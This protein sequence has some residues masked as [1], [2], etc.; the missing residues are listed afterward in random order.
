[1]KLKYLITPLCAV[2]LISAGPAT[3]Q[4]QSKP[5]GQIT[6]GWVKSTANL[7]AFVSPTISEQYGLKIESANFNTA[8]DIA[9]AMISGQVDVGLLT[10]IHLIR[11]I[12]TKI[13]FVQIAGNTRGNTGIVIAKKHGV[14]TDDW[15]GFK[16]LMKQKKLRL[17]SSRGSIN[18]LLAIAEFARNGVDID[19]DLDFVNIANFGQH[20][21][22]LRSGEFDVIV[23][24]EPL[25]AL[26]TVDGT[27]V[28]LSRPY[29]SA[30][31]DLNTNYVVRREW[32]AKNPELAQ[33]F[34]AT[35]VEASKRL[36][37]DKKAEL[38]AA[39]KLTG[40]KPDVLTVALSNNRYHLRN[41]LKQMQEL[42]RIA[43]ERQYVSRDVSAD[44]PKAVEDRF[45]KAA[46]ISE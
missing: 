38:D 5:I 7:M 35:L 10:P 36:S 20:P 16:K 45:L 42:A 40:M 13:D 21:Q 37:G 39:I 11:A 4:S 30:A 25:A 31:G 22:A 32:L 46:G 44:L 23:T 9:T 41:G 3:A 27:G 15:G 29:N 14:G 28:L 26:V 34:V 6:L 8:V 33:A 43:A 2:L 24:L 17:A 12:D 18:E 19:K 1:M